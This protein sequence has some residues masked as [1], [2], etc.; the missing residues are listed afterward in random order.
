V[1]EKQSAGFKEVQW[2]GTADN[3]VRVASGVYL[4][5]LEVKPLSGSKKSFVQSRKM[6]LLR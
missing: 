3:G 6:V 4:Y 1:N 2:D 5:R